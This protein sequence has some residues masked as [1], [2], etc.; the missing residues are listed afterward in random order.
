[1]VP[2]TTVGVDADEAAQRILAELMQ[3]IEGGEPPGEA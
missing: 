1:M 2:L 3:M